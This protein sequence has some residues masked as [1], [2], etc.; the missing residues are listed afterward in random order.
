MDPIPEATAAHALEEGIARQWPRYGKVEVRYNLISVYV[1]KS[2][3]YS[4]AVKRLEQAR[5]VLSAYKDESI[6]PYKPVIYTIGS[7]EERIGF[8]PLVELR[9][10][11]AILIDGT[12]RSLAAFREGLEE[13][14]AL[15]IR[16]N[17][18]PAPVRPARPLEDIK[19]VNGD[20]DR[21]SPFAG[22]GLQNFRPSALFTSDAEQRIKQLRTSVESMIRAERQS[23]LTR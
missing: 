9:H 22:K 6:E 7:G 16:A 15:T 20:M 19:V 14:C 11:E 23:G 21:L 8:G 17:H 10:G 3:I 2:V 4:V 1:L 5:N 13:I 18:A 12:H